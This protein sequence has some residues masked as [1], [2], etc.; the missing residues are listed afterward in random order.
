MDYIAVGHTVG[1]PSAESLAES[2]KALLSQPAASPMV[3][4]RCARW[5]GE[6]E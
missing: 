1:P 6:N 5:R 3:A 2:G 4:R